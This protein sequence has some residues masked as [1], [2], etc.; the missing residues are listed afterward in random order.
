MMKKI[1]AI[2]VST[3]LFIY[4]GGGKE[5]K[6]PEKTSESTSATTHQDITK[7]NKTS[8]PTSAPTKQTA[9]TTT[10]TK[11]TPPATFKSAP[12]DTSA[13]RPKSSPE[14]MTPQVKESPAVQPV[15]AIKTDSTTVRASVAAHTQQAKPLPETKPSPAP[16]AATTSTPPPTTVTVPEQTTKP[17]EAKP[18]PSSMSFSLN[19]LL[20]EDIYFDDG[21]WKNVSLSFNSNYFVT[22]AKI[23]KVLKGDPKINIRLKG[24][25]AQAAN[26]TKEKEIALKRAI[27]VGKMLIELFP[28]SEKESVAYRIEIVPVGSDEPLVQSTNKFQ[29]VLNRRVSIEIFEGQIAG[30]ALADY[31]IKGKP[32][33]LVPE[34]Q[35]QDTVKTAAKATPQ[36]APVSTAQKLTPVM[37][38]Y[39]AGNKLFA[40]GKYTES[41]S[42]FEELISLDRNDPLADNAQWWI[43]EAYYRQ[44]DY[45]EAL[46]A[47]QKVFE[48]GDKNKVAYAQLRIGYCYDK[49]NQKDMAVAS[50]EK[51]I[52]NYPQALE[53]VTKA[54]KALEIT[55]TK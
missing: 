19:N 20:F 38:L 51:V 47:Y 48:L 18:E 44:G 42:T 35:P 25:T 36:A 11:F 30:S 7:K 13:S 40:Q 23:V 3:M 55:G 8:V 28:Q 6:Q 49:L 37:A 31:V 39:S 29:E 21:E 27:T 41:I 15:T 46:T 32:T 1:A 12:V 45:V 5:T 54:R 24:H 52:Q 26:R 14:V 16:V 50:F 10:P 43:G 53:E 33:K 4:C 9:Q 17:S 34:A 22:L 2:A